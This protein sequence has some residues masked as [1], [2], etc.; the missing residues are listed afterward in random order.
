M[1][2]VTLKASA[3]FRLFEEKNKN[4][5]SSAVVFRWRLWN[6][7][8]V[9]DLWLELSSIYSREKIS[10]FL[11][12]EKI[13]NFISFTE[14]AVWLSHCGKVNSVKVKPKLQAQ[15]ALDT[16]VKQLIIANVHIW[17]SLFRKNIIFFSAPSKPITVLCFYL[18]LISVFSDH[19]IYPICHSVRNI[20]VRRQVLSFF[21]ISSALFTAL[22]LL[23]LYV[24][25]FAIVYITK[26]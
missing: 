21:D 11:A 10:Y 15:L 7:D 1:F 16:V 3:I 2:M 4:N 6:L 24:H 25:S 23:L 14:A 8:H 12:V 26:L 17:V 22:L 18:R 9:L 19:S 13:F 20:C 5:R